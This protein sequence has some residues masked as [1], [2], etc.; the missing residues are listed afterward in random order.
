MPVS[1]KEQK[2]VEEKVEVKEEKKSSPKAKAQTKSASAQKASRQK[3]E[4]PVAQ[5]IKVE[6]GQR[7]Q[8][9]SKEVCGKVLNFKSDKDGFLV[10]ATVLWDSG[11]QYAISSSD[12]KLV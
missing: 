5:K 10:K 7:V 2:K 3:K 4:K 9:L 1:K 11:L 8:R 6:V 12:L